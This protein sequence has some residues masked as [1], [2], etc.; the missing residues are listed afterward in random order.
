MQRVLQFKHETQK[1]G[2]ER[3]SFLSWYFESQQ[4][5]GRRRKSVIGVDFLYMPIMYSNFVS[6]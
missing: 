2:A 1:S 4:N 5:T 3:I 6:P